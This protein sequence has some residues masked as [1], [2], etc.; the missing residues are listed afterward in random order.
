MLVACVFGDLSQ[1]MSRRRLALKP[2]ALTSLT[3]WPQ[4]T[5]CSQNVSL[6]NQGIGTTS[7]F[8]WFSFSP[9]EAEKFNDAIRLF[10]M[11]GCLDY[12]YVRSTTSKN[13][14]VFGPGR[15]RSSLCTSFLHHPV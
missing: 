8:G 9:S 4:L 1:S 7:T 14:L 5:A 3:R 15:C 13:A 11:C 10:N 2:L 12:S 6:L